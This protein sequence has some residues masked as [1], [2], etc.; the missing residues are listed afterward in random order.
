MDLIYWGIIIMPLLLFAV[1]VIIV[2][3]HKHSE[4]TPKMTNSKRT[5]KHRRAKLK[6]EDFE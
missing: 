6:W 1:A 4:R 5:K 3:V 2:Y